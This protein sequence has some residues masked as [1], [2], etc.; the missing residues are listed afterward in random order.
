MC[1][2]VYKRTLLIKVIG[3]VTVPEEH[4]FYT[5]VQIGI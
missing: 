3:Q 4:S 2:Y 1:H 5:F